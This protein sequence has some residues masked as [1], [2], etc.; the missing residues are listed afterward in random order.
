VQI[1]R[2]KALTA[3]ADRQHRKHISLSPQRGTIY[4][5]INRILAIYFDTNS[6]YAV[7]KEIRNTERV[8]DIL[9]KK[10]VLD[11]ESLVRKLTVNRN[12]TWV[13]RK[14]DAETKDDIKKL[15]IKGIYLA[16]EGKRFYPGGRLSCH[17]LGITDIDNNGLEGIELY[18]DKELAGEKGWKHV[19]RDAKQREFFYHKED[20]LPARNGTNLVLTVDE[21]IQHV[22]EAEMENIVNL[23][24]P[25]G[26]SCIAMDPS[27]GEILGLANYPWF[28]PNKT[29]NVKLGHLRNRAISDSFEPGSVFKIVTAA[30]ALEEK[31]VDLDT[32]FFCEN[33]SYRLG[34]RILHDYKPFGKLT[35]R[36]IIEKSSNI[37][38]CKVASRLGKGKL[39]AYIKK[40]N[41]GKKTGVD[42]P[43]EV[44]GILRDVDSW[45]FSDMS[46]VPMGHGIAVTPLQMALCVS[47]IANNG[48]LMKPYVVKCLLNDEGTLIKENRPQVVRR[49]VS[50]ETAD[51]V[52]ELLL[53]VVE[54]GTGWRSR[55]DDFRVCGKTGTA[56]KV[57]PRGGY[58]KDKYISSFV[59]FAPFEKPR[60]VLAV[61]VDEPKGEHL[62]GRVGA[63]AFKNMMEKILFYLEAE[64]D[65][66]E[67]QI[68]T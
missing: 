37:G 57:N 14:L 7:P 63:P 13:K 11:R 19:Y 9:S 29:R 6:L 62:G 44:S 46:T 25:A 65:K 52:K 43:G 41:F 61:C 51:K 59:G 31:V 5:R 23:Y 4:D 42:L 40:F 54:R 12:F 45:S 28:D 66:R 68:S 58:H 32:E 38:V 27:T 56:E 48:V 50:K 34:K 1:I 15:K 18:Y 26:V 30:A 33:G 22:L 55:L 2:H 35:F 17:L 39:F 24:N 21:M 3:L 53:G 67:A 47:T 8:A 16:S 10:L 60:V 49:V 36:E 20:S 64:R